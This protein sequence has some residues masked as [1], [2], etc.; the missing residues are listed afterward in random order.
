MRIA[1]KVA[2][3]KKQDRKEENNTKKN[4][5]GGLRKNVLRIHQHVM[6]QDSARGKGTAVLSAGSA[7][8]GQ[9]EKHARLYRRHQKKRK[10]VALREEKTFYPQPPPIHTI[11]ARMR[12]VRKNRKTC[13]HF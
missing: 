9:M 4:L 13:F 2:K 11:A 12:C 1:Q 8:A 10:N 3:K 5:E 6:T 7:G